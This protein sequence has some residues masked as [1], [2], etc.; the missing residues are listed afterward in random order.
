MQR[1]SVLATITRKPLSPQSLVVPARQ[2]D[3]LVGIAPPQLIESLPPVPPRHLNVQEHQFDRTEMFPV[4]GEGLRTVAPLEHLPARGLQHRSR[5]LADH[6]LVVDDENVAGA[7]FAV[8]RMTRT[9]LPTWIARAFALAEI[10]TSEIPD[11]IVSL[12]S[13]SKT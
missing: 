4:D 7:A 8:E 2:Q 3:G 13:R 5:D 11:M 9:L 6:R 10:V 1:S 12:F